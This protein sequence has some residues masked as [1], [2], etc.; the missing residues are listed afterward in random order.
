MH[1]SKELRLEKNRAEGSE[2]GG[3]NASGGTR[4]EGLR[5][6]GG[7]EH[8]VWVTGKKTPNVDLYKEVE[9]VVVGRL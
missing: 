8:G 4:M 3:K 6:P 7:G 5:L 2:V 1:A 9:R